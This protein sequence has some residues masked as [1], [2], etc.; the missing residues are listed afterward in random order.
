MGCNRHA[1]DKARPSP[2]PWGFCSGRKRT[3]QP[4]HVTS[5]RR[6]QVGR[7]CSGKGLRGAGL[8]GLP[9]G[10]EER[11]H[12]ARG[13][14]CP[15]TLGVR[16]GARANL[17]FPRVGESVPAAGGRAVSCPARRLPPR[18]PASCGGR[19]RH[20]VV[21]LRRRRGARAPV[22]GCATGSLWAAWRRTGRR[23]RRW[24]TRVSR[25]PS[26]T[27]LP[28]PR[29]AGSRC[30]VQE[31]RRGRQVGE[32]AGRGCGRA[33]GRCG[34][35][36]ARRGE[37]RRAR[38][39]GG[40]APR[41]PR[42]PREPR[43]GPWRAW[44]RRA[45]TSGPGSCSC[46]GAGADAEGPG[47]GPGR[48]FPRGGSPGPGLSW[49]VRTPLRAAAGAGGRRGPS[50]SRCRP[51]RALRGSR[52]L[53]RGPWDPSFLF[54]C[55]RPSWL[56]L[57]MAGAECQVSRIPVRQSSPSHERPVGGCSASTARIKPKLGN[58]TV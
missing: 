18:P 48:P 40:C 7:R 27:A 17:A 28:V 43:L 25:R 39:G 10:R 46:G 4:Q 13:V 57:V 44:R 33:R 2:K 49:Q 19:G 11:R 24:P 34:R 26:A 9:E 8:Q 23:R 37:A 1:S 31:A 53:P 55:F 3:T 16:S 5:G 50:F 42:T 41:P 35:R 38:R 52:T 45:E 58:V 21:G 36:R 30:D 47:P 29:G 20:V 22:T 32:A 14:G 51:K 54:L 12:Q 15:R 6:S 56:S